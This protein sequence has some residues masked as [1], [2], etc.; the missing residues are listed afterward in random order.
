MR[1]CEKCGSYMQE[2]NKG[3]SCTKCGNLVTET[4]VEVKRIEPPESSP[5]EVVDKSKR[6]EEFTRVRETCPR[7]GNPEAY[8]SL[9]LVSGEHAGVRQERSM[10]RFTCTECAYTWTR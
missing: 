1:F 8:H 10:E 4:I 9:G 2:T 3:F 5:V 6:E 7:C